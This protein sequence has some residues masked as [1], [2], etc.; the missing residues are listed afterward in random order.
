MNM[1]KWTIIFLFIPLLGQSQ[2]KYGLKVTNYTEYQESLKTHPEKEL[3]DL[4]KFIPN[5]VLDIRYATTNNFV[6]EK[7]YNLSKAYARKSVAEALK[8][9]QIEFNKMRSEE[10]R[11]GKECA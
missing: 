4:E 7:I 9:A 2:Y 1:K 6:R 5:I 11:V 10:R 3:I 8:N